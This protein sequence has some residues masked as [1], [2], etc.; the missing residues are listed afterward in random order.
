MQ[1]TVFPCAPPVSESELKALEHLRNRLQSIGGAG[2]WVLLTNL[3]FSVTHH[4]QS[5]EIDVIVIGPPGVRV[6][7]VKHWGSQWMDSHADL[8]EQ[9]ADPR[10]E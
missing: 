9:E 7:E 4:L 6:I 5:D 1:V 3:A 8:V 2:Q 10:Y